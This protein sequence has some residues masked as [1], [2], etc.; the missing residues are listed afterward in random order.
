M[1]LKR[2]RGRCAT[3]PWKLIKNWLFMIVLV[4]L[5]EFLALQEV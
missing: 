2:L 1:I 4:L 3:I 5:T